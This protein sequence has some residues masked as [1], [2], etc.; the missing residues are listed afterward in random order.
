MQN[1][2]DYITEKFL[3]D[4]DTKID[5]EPSERYIMLVPRYSSDEFNNKLKNI[6][7]MW[8]SRR[9]GK[10]NLLLFVIENDKKTIDNVAAILR[11]YD[12]IESIDYTFYKYPEENIYKSLSVLYYH[13]RNNKID[14]IDLERIIIDVY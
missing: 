11:K 10:N 4:A 14:A 13:W 7:K 9:I 3:I 2:Q 6:A 12:L 5:N 1:I 8:S